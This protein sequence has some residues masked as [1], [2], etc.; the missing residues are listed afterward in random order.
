MLGGAACEFQGQPIGALSES[1]SSGEGDSGSDSEA[2][3]TTGGQ[4][5]CGDDTA[6]GALRWEAKLPDEQTSNFNAAMAVAVGDDCSVFVGGRIEDGTI[7]GGAMF[8]RRYDAYGT[9][10]W[11]TVVA[12]DPDRGEEPFDIAV[13]GDGSLVVV[14]QRSGADDGPSA[15]PM[16]WTFS[17]DGEMTAA[18]ERAYEANAVAVTSDGDVWVNDRDYGNE[19]ALRRLGESLSETAVIPGNFHHFVVGD[20]D[21]V[22]ALADLREDG[23]ALRVYEN[24]T[25]LAE[26]VDPQP[27]F[28][29]RVALADGGDVIIVRQNEGVSSIERVKPIV[30]ESVWRTAVD[31][32]P[33]DV[34]FTAGGTALVGGSVGNETAAVVAYDGDGALLWSTEIPGGTATSYPGAAIAADADGNAYFATGYTIPGTFNHQAWLIAV[35]G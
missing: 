7:I 17:A 20:D 16:L 23:N 1:S 3:G 25:L 4:A 15:I 33:N 6:P 5:V 28:L 32:S 30:G 10:S 26:V 9:L 8:I 34:A 21:R 19:G 24:L 18:I 11:S 35:G 31:I 13:Q 27:I 12:D 29:G 22:I 14:G 2:S